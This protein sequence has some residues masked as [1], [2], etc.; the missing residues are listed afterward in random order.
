MRNLFILLWKHNFAI[1]FLLMECMCNV[2]H[3]SDKYSSMQFRG[4]QQT[5]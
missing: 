3:L 5:V 2:P 1:L 4:I